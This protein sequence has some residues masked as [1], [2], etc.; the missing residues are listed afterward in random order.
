[1]TYLPPGK[2]TMR[3]QNRQLKQRIG[4]ILRFLQPAISYN[5]LRSRESYDGFDLYGDTRFCGTLTSHI[6]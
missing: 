4:R 3:H 1:M 2:F 5:Q 6:D